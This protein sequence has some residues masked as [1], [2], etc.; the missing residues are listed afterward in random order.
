IYNYT[1]ALYI[2]KVRIQEECIFR[3]EFL[4]GYQGSFPGLDHRQNVDRYAAVCSDPIHPM[5]NFMDWYI[6]N[7]LDA[8]YNGL[9]T[10]TCDGTSLEEKAGK[11]MSYRNHFNGV[12]GIIT[13]S[14]DIEEGN[15]K[16]EGALESFGQYLKQLDFAVQELMLRGVSAESWPLKAIIDQRDEIETQLNRIQENEGK[17]DFVFLHM[18]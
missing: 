5:A 16:Y 17:P 8:C 10:G 6:F 14:E 12:P 2:S 15:Y 1:G 3:K 9:T 7:V 11:E 18:C 13:F 4:E